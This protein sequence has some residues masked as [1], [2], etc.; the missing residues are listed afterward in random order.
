M[1][2]TRITRSITLMALAG[3]ALTA[4]APEAE[5]APFRKEKT[6]TLQ[7]LHFGSVHDPAVA[8]AHAEHQILVDD[9]RD[10]PNAD[11][12]S[13]YQPYLNP[14]F[15]NTVIAVLRPDGTT[16][17]TIPDAGSGQTIDVEGTYIRSGRNL[18]FSV[19]DAARNLDF[20]FIGKASKQDRKCYQG[21]AESR[22]P[23]FELTPLVA[24]WEGCR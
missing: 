18:A 6:L 22:P 24:Y 7:F 21:T 13:R 20:T 1:R 9:I 8:A 2:N 17:V 14:T 11:L 15:Y 19:A 4:L 16:T 12:S 23:G 5:A 10:V 3:L